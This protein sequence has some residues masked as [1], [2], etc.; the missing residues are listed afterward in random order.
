[1]GWFDDSEDDEVAQKKAK[2]ISLPSIESLLTSDEQPVTDEVCGKHE[3]EEDPLDAFMKNLQSGNDSSVGSKKP[4]STNIRAEKRMDLGL[5]DD[6][7]VDDEVADHSGN[8]DEVSKSSKI[9]DNEHPTSQQSEDTL[10]ALQRTFRKE[11]TNSSVECDFHGNNSDGNAPSKQ[12]TTASSEKKST[13]FRKTFWEATATMKGQEWRKTNDVHCTAPIDPVLEFEGLSSPFG[14]ILLDSIRKKGY[15][16]PTLV[17]SQ[18]LPVALSGR[19]VLVTAA[20]GQGKTLAYIWPLVVHIMDQPHLENETGPIA[21]VLVPTRELAQQVFLQ[22]KGMLTPFRGRAKAVIGGQGK[23][24]LQQELKKNGGV[25]LVVAT[26]GRL[27]DVLSDKKG[28]S[29]CRVTAVVLDEAD[30]MLDM[31][32]ESQVRQLLAAIRSDRQTFM[33]SATMGRKIEKVATEWLAEDFVRISVGRT[34]ESSQNVQQHV[35]VFRNDKMKEDFIIELLPALKEVGLTLVFVAT[36]DGCEHLAL[37]IQEALPTLQVATL[38]GNKHQ[39]DRTAALRSFARGLVSTLIATDVAGRGLDIPNVATVVNFDQAKNLDTH[40]H[41][42]GRA[43]RLS[44]DE[45][46]TGSAY[47]LLTP[48]NAAFASVL[49]NAFEREHR[50]VP[51]ELAELA[52]SNRFAANSATKKNSNKTGLGFEDVDV[53]APVHNRGAMGLNP[54]LH[55]ADSDAP[56]SKRGRFS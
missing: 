44:R 50:P 43:G 24:L 20:T 21:L 10:N 12:F 40:I 7:H 1:M 46:K 5:E 31:G 33:L 45:Q 47:T 37:R 38:H 39:S 13:P 15:S 49:K 53:A 17:Q 32:F 54:S 42:I 35:M 16:K 28:L 6:E 56:P 48:K 25:E 19:D 14:D 51:R 55:F 34:G 41:R 30:K 8:F 26:P 18:T 22:A 52:E 27:L 36:K 4:H 11:S 3:A 29:L 2:P 9:G 23:Y